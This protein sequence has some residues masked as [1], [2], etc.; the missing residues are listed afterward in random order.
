M[1]ENG[2]SLR[3]RRCRLSLQRAGKLVFAQVKDLSGGSF[4]RNGMEQA[5]DSQNG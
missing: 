2:L 4:R 3:C 1:N 5:K